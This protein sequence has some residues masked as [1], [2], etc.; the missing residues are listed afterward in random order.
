MKTE[1]KIV[2]IEEKIK[3]S[4]LVVIINKFSY[5]LAVTGL[6]GYIL[7]FNL[8]NNEISVILRFTSI[9]FY[10]LAVVISTGHIMKGIVAKVL[11]RRDYAYL[12][13]NIAVFSAISYIFIVITALM[14]MTN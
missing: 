9:Y 6:G 10:F 8:Q 12:I 5:L 11:K 3:Y 1:N 14:S 7:S 4:N 2:T 13:P